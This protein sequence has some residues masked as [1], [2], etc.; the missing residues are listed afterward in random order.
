MSFS[1]RLTNILGSYVPALGRAGTRLQVKQYRSSNGRKGDRFLGSPC[2][3]LDVVG[4]KS[5]ASHPVM[6]IHVPRGDD[7]VVVGS[8]AGIAHTPNWYKNLIAAGGGHVQVGADRWRVE[9]FE[10]PEGP[11]RDECWALAVA[12]YPGFEAYRTYTPRRIP[13]AVLKRADR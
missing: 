11:E 8:G 1:S 5:G 13:V 10:L 6:L 7:L 2:F 4:R 9:A 12:R 3:L